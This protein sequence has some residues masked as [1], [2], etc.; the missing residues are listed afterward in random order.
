MPDTDQG[1][2]EKEDGPGTKSEATTTAAKHADSRNDTALPRQCAAD[3]RPWRQRRQASYRLIPL[4]CGCRDPW[5]CRCTVPPLSDKTVDAGRAAALHVLDQGRVPLHHVPKNLEGRGRDAYGSVHKGNAIDGAR[6]VLDNVEPFGRGLRG[7]SYVYV[8]KDRPGQLR[9]EGRS[10]KLPGKTFFGTLVVDASDEGPDFLT[11]WAPKDAADPVGPGDKLTV[12]SNELA[13]LVYEVL[14]ALPDRTVRSQ[15]ELF[16]LMRTSG[17]PFR[18][19]AMRGAVDDLIVTGRLI[20]VP[21]K[22]GARGYR[23]VL[24]AAR[25]SFNQP[26]SA[27]AARTAAPIERG[28]G[29]QSGQECGPALGRS[30]P[31]SAAVEGNGIPLSSCRYCETPIADH[32]H[33]QIARGY[34]NAPP[35][36]EAAQGVTA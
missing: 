33:S 26:P 21:G 35:C 30:G 15:R 20:E 24:T 25:G 19:G 8:T 14:A 9:A 6:I 10:T 5:P 2:P 4:D 11:F 34:C 32:M 27:T 31:Q 7:V 22:R 1:P 36:L 23:A 13:D 28:R 18:E 17:H 12:T 16:A 29:P 3:T